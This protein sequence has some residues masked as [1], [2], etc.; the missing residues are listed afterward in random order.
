MNFKR[1]EMKVLLVDL[2]RYPYAYFPQLK[3][4][5]NIEENH[6]YSEDFDDTF[7]DEYYSFPEEKLFGYDDLN[8]LLAAFCRKIE[9]DYFK[10]V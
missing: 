7:F 1:D 9:Y 6:V 10:V 4:G 3:R 8:D 2:S 5:M